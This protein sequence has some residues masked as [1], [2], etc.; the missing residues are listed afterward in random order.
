M[1]KIL[2]RVLS[3]VVIASAGSAESFSLGG[4]FQKN[5][6]IALSKT[7]GGVGGGISSNYT[8]VFVTDAPS[9]IAADDVTL[10]DER[11][12]GE[13]PVEVAKMDMNAIVK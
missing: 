1:K 3:V 8:K 12:R 2:H 4:E 10:N 13:D 7:S 11:L 9:V 6:P 5:P